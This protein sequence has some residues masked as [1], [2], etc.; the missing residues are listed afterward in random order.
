MA[1]RCCATLRSFYEGFASRRPT[2]VA[3]KSGQ[4]KGT[5]AHAPALCSTAGGLPEQAAI[6]SINL[7]ML[8]TMRSKNE[9]FDPSIFYSSPERSIFERSNYERIQHPEITSFYL[10][11]E[12][13][14]LT[15]SARRP[16][17]PSF[18]ASGAGMRSSKNCGALRSNAQ[19]LSGVRGDVV[20]PAAGGSL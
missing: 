12:H 17:D 14:A 16:F 20:S 4:G 13:P 15:I 11:I 8:N 18:Q 7:K 10:A 5:R 19:P 3:P 9:C 1:P 2:P 6:I